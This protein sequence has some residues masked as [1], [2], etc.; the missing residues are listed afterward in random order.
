ML[1]VGQPGDG[2]VECGGR[3][4]RGRQRLPAV[5]HLDIALGLELAQFTK[6]YVR[7]ARQPRSFIPERPHAVGHAARQRLGAGRLWLLT[8]E[9]AEGQ[10]GD[11]KNPC[12]ASRVSLRRRAASEGHWARHVPGIESGWCVSWELMSAPGGS[13]SP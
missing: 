5:F 6:E 4:T 3:V 11:E 12:D 10:E 7:L 13:E 9:G 8:V 2:V 1:E